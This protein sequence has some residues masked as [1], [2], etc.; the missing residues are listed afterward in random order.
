MRD[1]PCRLP[2]A[3]AEE[4]V[5]AGDQQLV[6]QLERRGDVAA[7]VSGNPGFTRPNI[8]PDELLVFLTMPDST[9]TSFDDLRD[10]SPTDVPMQWRFARDALQSPELGVSHFTYKPGARMPWG[11][12][13][14]AQEEVYVVVAGSGRAKLDDDV[15]DIG[16]WDALRVAPAVIRSFEAGPDGLE[17]SASAAARRK[18]LTASGFRT[19]GADHGADSR[20]R[21]SRPDVWRLK[22]RRCPRRRNHQRR[23]TGFAAIAEQWPP[24]CLAP[25]VPSARRAHGPLLIPQ[26]F[27][28]PCDAQPGGRSL[29]GS[30][31]ECMDDVDLVQEALAHAVE[32]IERAACALTV[33]TMLAPRQSALA[34]D[35][36][37]LAEAVEAEIAAVRCTMSRR[38]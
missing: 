37:V 20:S 27:G 30:T 11:H 2:G 16:T 1:Q 4:Q 21:T 35:A 18:G 26:V 6:A 8:E 7:R 22:I 33:A 9:K 32:A 34:R 31:T 24:F 25:R 15:I 36:Y 29:P 19:S 14:R 12:R 13:H 17:I 10:V 5:A 3:H 23:S 38:C 28:S